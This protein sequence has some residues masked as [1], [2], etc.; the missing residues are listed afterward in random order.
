MFFEICLVLEVETVNVLVLVHQEL[1]V[2]AQSIYLHPLEFLALNNDNAFVTFVSLEV[3]IITV[4]HLLHSR[5]I[6]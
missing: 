2:A 5:L 6:L 3:T 4:V 1:L